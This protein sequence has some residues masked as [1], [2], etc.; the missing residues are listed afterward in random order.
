MR[1][2]HHNRYFFVEGIKSK[3]KIVFNRRNEE[4][5]FDKYLQYLCLVNDESVNFEGFTLCH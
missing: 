1:Q 2:Q 5:F 4:V 3:R